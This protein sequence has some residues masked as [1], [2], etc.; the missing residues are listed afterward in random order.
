[1]GRLSSV[2]FQ[3]LK[4]ELGEIEKLGS[5]LSTLEPGPQNFLELFDL[6][7]ALLET[8]QVG[9]LKFELGAKDIRSPLFHLAPPL[10][11]S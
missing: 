5:K 10:S 7:M 1:M 3:R 9:G 6:D 8:L 11:L 4:V 2:G